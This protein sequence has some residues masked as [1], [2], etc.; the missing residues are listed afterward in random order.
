MNLVLMR[1]SAHHAVYN[2]SITGVIVLSNEMIIDIILMR[3]WHTISS[4]KL[5]FRSGQGQLP[6][7]LLLLG[8]RS[9][10]VIY[11]KSNQIS[12]NR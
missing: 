5:D 6:Y 2:I 12:K 11:P 7:I 10:H 3:L 1:R 8:N 9:C 4:L